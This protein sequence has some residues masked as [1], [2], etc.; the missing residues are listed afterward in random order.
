MYE[1]GANH[2]GKGAYSFLVWAPF[3]KT[4]ELSLLAP[5]KQTVAMRRREDGYFEAVVSGLEGEPPQYVFVLDGE[6]IRPDPVSHFQPEGVHQ[7][8]QAVIHEKFEWRD[9]GWWNLPLAEYLI[10]E[11]HVG[12]F[13]PE[14][15]FEAV[16]PRLKYLREE[17]GVTAIE[18]MPVAQF[19]GTRN[20]GYDGVHLY[21]VQNSYGGPEG[22]KSLVNGCHEA[23]LAVILD[24]VYNHLGPEGNYLCDFGPYFTSRHQTPWGSA[25][26][27]DGPHC[28]EVRRFFVDNALYW[29]DKYHIDALRLDAV[30]SILDFSANH[31]LRELK[32][33]ISTRA[34]RKAYLI[35]ESDLNDVRLINPR[36][37]GGYGLKAQWLDDYHHS[38]HALLTGEKQGYYLD[39]GTTVHLASS[40]ENGFV[41]SGQYSRHRHRSFGNSSRTRPARQFVVF[42]QNHDQVGNRALGD[43]LS[44][45]LSLA[46]LKIAAAMV[47]LSPYIPLLF[48]GEEYGETAPF[49]YFIDHLDDDLAKA[50]G[51]GRR[52]EFAAFDWREEVP[53]PKAE[54]TFTRSKLDFELRHRDW[55]GEL[56]RFYRELIQLRKSH[57]VLRTP[58]KSG[59]EIASDPE[60]ATL[61]MLRTKWN[62]RIFYAVNFNDTEQPVTSGL[63]GSWRLLISSPAQEGSAPPESRNIEGELTLPPH[64]FFLYELENI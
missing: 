54:S 36:N 21:G 29:I 26:N 15:T 12:T 38:L 42:S 64:S 35:A 32:D 62:R 18:I 13:T 24:V 19:P 2:L 45:N 52:E 4:V 51:Q 53:D 49:Q 44:Q 61:T 47:L 7:P 59:L 39:F 30:H 5:R 8:S 23:G 1:L 25:I 37:M 60:R 9:E 17:L 48:M 3:R 31:I 43:R 10:Y 33:E 16:L 56:F 55:H 41:Y 6:L 22:L 14:G 57:P 34:T 58:D 20:W 50:V 27:F 63:A 46:K 40:L 11:L 28:D